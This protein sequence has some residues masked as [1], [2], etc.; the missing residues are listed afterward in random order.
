M[1]LT[2]VCIHSYVVLVSALENPATYWTSKRGVSQD[3]R[4]CYNASNIKQLS[5]I[6]NQRN[7]STVHLHNK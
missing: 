6:N 5:R 1:Y 3:E 2:Y 4:F 7:T